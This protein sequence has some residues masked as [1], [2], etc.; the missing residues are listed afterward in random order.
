[1][2]RLDVFAL[3][4]VFISS[5]ILGDALNFAIGSKMGRWAIDKGLV[6]EEFLSK[7]EK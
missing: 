3:L 5:A 7:T 4:A 1:M 2:G 6:K